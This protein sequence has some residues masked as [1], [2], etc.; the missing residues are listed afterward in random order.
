MVTGQV[1]ATHLSGYRCTAVATVGGGR[2]SEKAKR[3]AA[4][5]LGR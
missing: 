4:A 3:T 5:I 1:S 2:A